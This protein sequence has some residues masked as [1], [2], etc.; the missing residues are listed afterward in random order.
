MIIFIL[1]Q[2]VIS[3]SIDDVNIFIGTNN[4]G[5]F[6]HGNVYPAITVPFSSLS[7]SFQTNSKIEDGWL[8][9]PGD[10]SLNG[11]VRDFPAKISIFQ[12]N[13]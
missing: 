1:F 4:K 8:Y 5:S 13:F 2:L 7:V 12:P 11:W 9:N 10:S 3:Q 6:S